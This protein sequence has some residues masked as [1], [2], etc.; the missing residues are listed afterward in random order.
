M[1]TKSTLR[2]AL[3]F[4][5]ISGST[6]RLQ[7]KTLKAVEPYI[8][9]KDGV[10]VLNEQGEQIAELCRHYK[11]HQYLLDKGYELVR[12]ESGQKFVYK[13]KE[14]QK[15]YARLDGKHSKLF[16]NSKFHKQFRNGIEQEVV[17]A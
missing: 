17:P 5:H 12:A 9:E 13:H 2:Y 10:F 8:E 11:A 4:I 7:E 15:N 14:K 1:T 3:T 16:I 6:K